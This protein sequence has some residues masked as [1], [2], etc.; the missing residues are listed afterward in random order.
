VE[1]PNAAADALLAANPDLDPKLT[2]AE[3][4]ATLPLLQPSLP[5]KPYGYMDPAGWGNFIGW[6]RDNE[7]IST[8]PATSEVL[9]ND[10]LPGKIPE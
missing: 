1:R 10:Y 9:S 3:V 2:R 8:L 6:M 5:G 7:L 4:A